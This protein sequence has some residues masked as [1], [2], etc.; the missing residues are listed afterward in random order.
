MKNRRGDILYW[1]ALVLLGVATLLPL[2][3]MVNTSFKSTAEAYSD[4]PKFWPERMQWENFAAAFTRFPFLRYLGNTLFLTVL[5]VVGTLVTCTLVAWGFARYKARYNRPLFMLCLATMMLPPQVTSIP[6]FTLY[7][8]LGLYNTYVPLILGSWLAQSA[9]FI[10]LLKQFFEAIPEDLLNAA[11]IDG[12]GEFGTLW[13][14]AMPLSKPILWTVAVFT[15]LN[16]WNDYFGPLIYLID[17]QK[18]PLSLGLTYFV[19]SSKDA[20]FGTQWNLMMA[21]SMITMIP[22]AVLFFLA[23]RSFVDNA[24]SGGL[25]V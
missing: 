24:L 23:Q 9:F 13:R 17:E 7:V 6:V 4:P 22:V 11:R 12:C 15:C 8:K 3:F 2:L 5:R 1:T 21:V 10:F 18:Y 14:I 25:K 16:S 19:S 20:S